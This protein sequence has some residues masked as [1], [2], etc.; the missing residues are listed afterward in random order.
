MGKYLMLWEIDTTKLP[1]SPKERGAGW[2]ALMEIV[3]QD[4]KKG[5]TKDW[6]AFVGELRGYSIGEGS[7]V[8]LMNTLQQF[9]P[10][11]HFKVHPISSVSQVEE[12][13]KDMVK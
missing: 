11:V 7:E 1:V 10:F 13:I 4:M 12:M 9:S 3:K 8:E 6:G 5:I 2:K